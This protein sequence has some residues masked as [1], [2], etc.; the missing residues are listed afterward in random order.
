LTICHSALTQ[1]DKEFLLAVKRGDVDWNSF[2]LPEVQHLPAIQ[3]KLQN[4]AQMQVQKRKIAL[5]CS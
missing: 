5:E 4:L 1:E 3:W 2:I